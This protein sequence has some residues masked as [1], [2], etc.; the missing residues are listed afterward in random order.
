MRCAFVNAGPCA[1][2]V[3]YILSWLLNFYSSV[4]P[5]LS[6]WVRT[7]RCEWQ[8]RNSNHLK[9]KEFMDRGGAGLRLNRIQGLEWF[10][11]AAHLHSLSLFLLSLS[12]HSSFSHPC[13]SLSLTL[14]CCR[15]A[16]FIRQKTL[17]TPILS[18]QLNPARGKRIY[19]SS[20]QN[21]LTLENI[22]I[23]LNWITR[24]LLTFRP[25]TAAKEK[26]YRNT[27]IIFINI[28]IVTPLLIFKNPLSPL[29]AGK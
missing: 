11:L 17:W 3:L 4:K 7:L 26:R 14:F 28:N 29:A 12:L 27:I 6:I 10:Q 19:F 18:A 8:T 5:N 15:Q 22:L 16:C 20:L 25:I 13:H 2:N 24:L 21:K 9:R 23:V 1:P